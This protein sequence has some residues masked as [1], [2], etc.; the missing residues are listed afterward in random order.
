MEFLFGRLRSR[1]SKTIRSL[2]NVVTIQSINCHPA[3]RRVYRFEASQSSN[4]FIEDLPSTATRPRL[5]HQRYG[6]GWKRFSGSQASRLVFEYNERRG[7]GRKFNRHVWGEN[8]NNQK[9]IVLR[10]RFEFVR[11]IVSE[12]E[13]VDRTTT[14]RWSIAVGSTS[15]SQPT[16]RW[17]WC[18]RRIW[19]DRAVE[20]GR[21]HFRTVGTSC[22]P[23]RISMDD[24][25]IFSMHCHMFGR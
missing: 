17:K 8:G 10:K 13:F 21:I 24:D 6:K 7:S 16:K 20:S 3:G 11:S 2:S 19:R 18:G 1:T 14:E 23:V 25:R 4:L 22:T 12:F 15:S 5:V 9:R